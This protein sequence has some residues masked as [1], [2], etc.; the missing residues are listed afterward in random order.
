MRSAISQTGAG[1]P[2]QQTYEQVRSEKDARCQQPAPITAQYRGSL[3]RR[4]HRRC[5]V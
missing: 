2:L 1:Y 4:R 3:C 5:H